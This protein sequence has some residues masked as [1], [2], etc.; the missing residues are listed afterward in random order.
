MTT[1]E[2]IRKV[3]RTVYPS[4]LHKG[5]FDLTPPVRLISGDI[6]VGCYMINP[7]G[8]TVRVVGKSGFGY[9]VDP[10]HFEI[11]DDQ[12]KLAE[13][14]EETWIELEELLNQVANEREEDSD[15]PGSMPTN[16]ARKAR[17]MLDKLWME[18]RKPGNIL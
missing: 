17:F 18:R 11:S 6:V 1:L 9:W 8:Q 14:P 4:F 3:A 5:C 2:E 7:I 10:T 15:G 16:N 13:I 12:K